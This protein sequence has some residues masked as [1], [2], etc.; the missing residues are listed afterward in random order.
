M[1]VIEEAG[2]FG[3]SE[4]SRSGGPYG[5]LHWSD[6]DDNKHLELSLP[7]SDVPQLQCASSC[8]EA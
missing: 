3:A 5:A 4:R 8:G 6:G 2:P 1:Q 7:I